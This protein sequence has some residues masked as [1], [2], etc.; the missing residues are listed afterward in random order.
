[1]RAQLDLISSA[2]AEELLTS[3]HVPSSSPSVR[4]PR[5]A[6]YLSPAPALRRYAPFFVPHQPTEEAETLP[7]PQHLKVLIAVAFFL[8]QCH[9]EV[10]CQVCP[11]GTLHP[12]QGF[13]E[14]FAAGPGC[15]ARERGDTETHVI[16]VGRA[17]PGSQKQVKVLLRPLSYSQ[18]PT[19]SLTLVL[20]SQRPIHWTLEG[21]RLPPRLSVRVEMAPASTM[22]ARGVALQV[23]QVPGLPRRPRALLHWSLERHSSISS[24]THTTLANRV[25]IR[26]GEDPTMPNVC[27][28]QSLFLSHN[29]LITHLQPQEVRGCV[30]WGHGSDLEVH[31]IKLQSAGSGIC[32]SLQVE[33]PVSVLPPVAH[34]GW[35][36]LVLILSSAVPVNWAV[37]AEGLQGQIS[38]YSSNTVSPLYP[39]EPDLS[40]TSMLTPDLL[41]THDLVGWANRSGFPKV[42]SYTEADLAN[43]FV[44]RLAGG[45]TERIQR[46]TWKI[47]SRKTGH[48]KQHTR[49]TYKEKL[50][51]D[52]VLSL[53]S[54]AVWPRGTPRS[55]EGR[56]LRAWLTQGGNETE[57]AVSVQCIDGQFSLAMDQGVLQS[58]S[59]P[60]SA[61][62]LRDPRCKAHFN[63]SHFLLVFPVIS[64]GTDAVM[65]AEPRGVR[66]RN[67]V[68]LWSSKAPVGMWNG[69]WEE[70]ADQQIP[71]LI[72]FSCLA[73]V[74]TPPSAPQDTSSLLW[75]EQ[76]GQDMDLGRSVAP[77][78]SLQLFVT[79]AFE[80]R[81]MGPCVIMADNR[82]YVEVSVTGM[83]R[84]GVE[85]HSCVVSPLSDPQAN[86][87]WPVIQDGCAFD[88]SL[89]LSPEVA[90]RV[91]ARVGE[92]TVKEEVRGERGEAEEGRPA[93]R[94]RFSF[95]LRPVY[96]NSIQ[97]LHCR[98][99]QCEEGPQRVTSHDSCHH[100]P[101][102]PTLIAKP[103][104]Q[105]CKYR[106]LSRPVLVTQSF[107]LARLLAPSAGQRAH[108]PNLKP[109][110]KSSLAKNSTGVDTGPVVGIVFAAFLIGISLMG[111]LWCI[112]THTGVALPQRR[113]S[114]P[115]T[116]DQTTASWNP[117]ASQEQSNSSV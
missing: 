74:P 11:A 15:A 54:L 58:L 49:S 104:N 93:D 64:C 55:G 67:S 90:G 35:Y 117:P 7:L 14:S 95:V 41:T 40:L 59:P 111:A 60:V 31:V 43:R 20:S 76:K 96:N 69:T 37:T 98:L 91:R 21:E 56:Q 88:P 110:S 83:I 18:P 113:G 86:P 100:G 103:R 32:G 39:P 17:S 25:Y 51:G 5:S 107:G 105:Q 102:L 26:L 53:Q 81:E 94:V 36:K 108:K 80:Q 24:L 97:F 19:R 77:L 65:E 78:F 116:M 73:V 2:A 1:M 8:N 114:L 27:R 101:A 46:L 4:D 115:E 112:Y 28:L 68:L 48:G 89:T 38:I 71:Q 29:Y 34:A 6:V 66:Y 61:V 92:E 84:E 70:P 42:T 52:W 99:R 45:G 22:Q 57:E 33:V 10:Q 12:V 44:I 16:S 23:M 63:G 72:H 82:V 3:S 85:V 87:G 62:T 106:T 47:V 109:L 30:P 9:V 50:Q 75:G 79:E 13:L